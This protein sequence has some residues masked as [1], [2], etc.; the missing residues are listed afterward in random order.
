MSEDVSFEID[1]HGIAQE[2]HHHDGFDVHVTYYTKSVAGPNTQPMYSCWVVTADGR[3]SKQ[4][5]DIE[6]DSF[7]PLLDETVWDKITD[8]VIE[9]PTMGV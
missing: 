4:M 6:K 7:H 8:F 3:K 1:R 2:I 9:T 5:N